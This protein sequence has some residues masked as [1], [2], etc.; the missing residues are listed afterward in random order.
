MSHL[1]W[2]SPLSISLLLLAVSISLYISAHALKTLASIGNEAARRD[3]ERD[4]VRRE[5]DALRLEEH[6]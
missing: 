2:E 1:V 6:A 3:V 5:V 4:K